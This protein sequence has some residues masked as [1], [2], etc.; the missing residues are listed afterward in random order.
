M[1][2]VKQQEQQLIRIRG[3]DT[4]ASSTGSSLAGFLSTT[5]TVE[6]FLIG[7]LEVCEQMFNLGQ[8]QPR[9]LWKYT[10]ASIDVGKGHHH[11]HPREKRYCSSA[12]LYFQ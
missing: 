9:Q 3:E 11:R 4:F 10:W 12:Q 1:A 2:E 7:G 5:P 6:V 8:G